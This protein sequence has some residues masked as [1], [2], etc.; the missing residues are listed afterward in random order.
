MESG[1]RPGH[2]NEEEKKTHGI[3]LKILKICIF[4]E[5]V[6]FQGFESEQEKVRYV[7][8]R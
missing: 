1:Q 6:R 5:T 4:V 2:T 8:P 7:P 3:K